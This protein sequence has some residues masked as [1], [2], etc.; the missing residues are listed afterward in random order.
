MPAGFILANFYEAWWRFAIVEGRRAGYIYIDQCNW[1]PLLG[2][3]YQASVA[4]EMSVIALS[5]I[6]SV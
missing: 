1:I 6:A 2:N 4:I 3:A 5:F